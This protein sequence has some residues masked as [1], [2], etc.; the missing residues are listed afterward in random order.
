MVDGNQAREKWLAKAKRVRV[1]VFDLDSSLDDYETVTKE[2]A[3]SGSNAQPM[4]W[5]CRR[6]CIGLYRPK[7]HLTIFSLER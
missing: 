1:I 4:R 6:R 7:T 5:A 3:C 2:F